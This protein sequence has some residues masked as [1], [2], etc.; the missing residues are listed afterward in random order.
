MNVLELSDVENS[1]TNLS[2]YNINGKET[3][4]HS[5]P[6][7]Q[8]FSITNATVPVEHLATSPVNT[9]AN[10]EARFIPE[11]TD[12]D[13]FFHSPLT[14]QAAVQ[15]LPNPD[16]NQNFNYPDKFHPLN[17][18]RGFDELRS[19]NQPSNS[20]IAPVELTPL[21]RRSRNQL[22]GEGSLDRMKSPDAV[23]KIDKLSN[24][25]NKLL[26]ETH[27]P[28][29]QT[30]KTRPKSATERLFPEGVV[31]PP[32]SP[33]SSQTPID[34]SRSRP[35]SQSSENV[36]SPTINRKMSDHNDPYKHNSADNKPAPGDLTSKSPPMGFK[37]TAQPPPLTIP[38][39][40]RLSNAS[41]YNSDRDSQTSTPV[42]PKSRRNWSTEYDGDFE[43]ADDLLKR[44]KQTSKEFDV[45]PNEPIYE[46][47]NNPT[48]FSDDYNLGDLR[49]VESLS[50]KPPSTIGEDSRDY[51]SLLDDSKVN[52]DDFSLSAIDDERMRK[53]FHTTPEDTLTEEKFP[54]K[55][56]SLSLEREPCP[57][58]RRLEL[59]YGTNMVQQLQPDEIAEFYDQI[60]ATTLAVASEQSY[61]NNVMHGPITDI[62]S[63]QHNDIPLTRENS[64][65]S[66]KS[67]LSIASTN[68]TY[69]VL[70]SPEK[71]ADRRAP[72]FS[73]TGHKSEYSNQPRFGITPNSS[74]DDL[75]AFKDSFPVPQKQTFQVPEENVREI[76]R[77]KLPGSLRN[78][79]SRPPQIPRPHARNIGS[80]PKDP[81]SEKTSSGNIE[82][83][84]HPS[85][86]PTNRKISPIHE[87]E[88]HE[89][90]DI[91][92]SKTNIVSPTT[93]HTS[94]RNTPPVK[95]SN[96][97]MDRYLN[98]PIYNPG[99]GR[100]QDPTTSAPKNRKGVNGLKP[101]TST[102]ETVSESRNSFTILLDETEKDGEI[103]YASTPTIL[104][105]STINE[106]KQ[107]DDHTKWKQK[108]IVDTKST[109]NS[110][111][112]KSS[113]SEGKNP[114]SVVELD[115][116]Q[117]AAV[118][119]I[120]Y[121]E[122]KSKFAQE[123]D[124]TDK[125]RKPM[126]TR[127]NPRGVGH[128]NKPPSLREK[129]RRQNIERTPP[130]KLNHEVLQ[131][132]LSKN[133][134][135]EPKSH[136]RQQSPSK[137][138]VAI[139]EARLN[140]Q[141]EQ[142]QKHR[143][144]NPE[145]PSRPKRVEIARPETSRSK[146]AEKM[147]DLTPDKGLT[148]P[149][150]SSKLALSASTSKSPP[151]NRGDSRPRDRSKDE[152]MGFNAALDSFRSPSRKSSPS[153]RNS[154]RVT[155]QNS[156][157]QNSRTSNPRYIPPPVR[158]P[159][160]KSPAHRDSKTAPEK[161]PVIVSKLPS[162]F[163]LSQND[164]KAKRNFFEI[165]A[166]LA[167]KPSGADSSAAKPKPASKP[168][169]KIDD[170][171]HKAATWI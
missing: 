70:P 47:F 170:Q 137:I 90:P 23:E 143:K 30:K 98:D 120:S 104:K 95:D 121:D 53:S 102:I 106:S 5:E 111:L 51:M 3:P 39:T 164:F 167:K 145:K 55:G 71:F 116:R 169:I 112:P 74:E 154:P 129:K 35:L 160:K 109:R 49:R 135:V 156:F 57:D 147:K 6:D 108:Q 82:P 124:P 37:T 64:S 85:V 134:S 130:E 40:Q 132:R 140:K 36:L 78:S 162:N 142:T 93:R 75:E 91:K 27:E 34:I 67:N 107:A 122:W 128:K 41:E 139:N 161:K 103:S 31:T 94:P 171:S 146:S 48:M 133:E 45:N 117:P 119:L 136:I 158:T 131:E 68:K 44:V 84:R 126:K 20:H 58:P 26:Q 97:R 155:P 1:D 110:K 150:Q 2:Q 43:V 12:H 86:T 61:P 69:D 73:T 144:L 100:S 54:F 56:N 114:V 83:E 141:N 168:V 118:N 113:Q 163:K 9:A 101:N 21:P 42:R 66:S 79:S 62:N 138:P 32:K 125:I 149:Q 89:T 59:N 25:L 166:Q 33:F 76:T 152:K 123:V 127:R 15:T 96:P 13:D 4:N 10:M 19:S 46:D 38:Q 88:E 99:R 52:I 151:G 81:E 28:D 63:Y 65:P 60:P 115:Y 11:I 92:D 22:Q 14:K 16:T 29:T 153:P 72:N 80:H 18:D 157:E 87:L 8:R 159:M 148:R 165:S 77:G 24:E 50:R 105:D 17:T 7:R